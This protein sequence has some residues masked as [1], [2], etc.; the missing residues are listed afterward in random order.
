MY[1]KM[2]KTKIFT[3]FLF[4]SLLNSSLASPKIDVKT[5]IL[6]DYNS[7][8]ILYELEPGINK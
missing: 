3:F 7:D 8:K 2:I 6:V 4:F 1:N 5:A